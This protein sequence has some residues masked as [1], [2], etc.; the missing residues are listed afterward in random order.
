VRDDDKRKLMLILFNRY[1][2]DAFRINVPMLS[3]MSGRAPKRVI[4]ILKELVDE[5]RIE[6]DRKT[7][8]AKIIKPHFIPDPRPWW[9]WD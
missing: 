9:T 5:G 1:R 2:Q 4:G 3:R 7:G 6:W 8:T